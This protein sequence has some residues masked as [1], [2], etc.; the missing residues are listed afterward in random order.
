MR[1]SYLKNVVE[2]D[3][4]ALRSIAAEAGVTTGSLYYYFS[5][6]EEIVLEILDTGHRQIHEEVVR[7]IEA[8]PSGA[9]RAA[10][11]RAGVRAHVAAPFEPG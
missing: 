10:K 11:V 4:P 7:A 2:Q 5:D 9:G 8:L 1:K 6:K 3:H